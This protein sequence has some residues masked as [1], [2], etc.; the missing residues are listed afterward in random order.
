MPRHSPGRI[1]VECAASIR[2]QDDHKNRWSLH[3]KTA[4]VTGGTRGIG[5]AVAE[6]LL[7]LGARVHTCARNAVELQACL[8]EWVGRGY[9]I[10]GSVCD[11]SIREQRVDLMENVSSLFDGNLDILVRECLLLLLLHLSH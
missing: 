5:K 4:L 7:G 9:S 1:L 3:G 11:V 8:S 6:E 2:S 10:S